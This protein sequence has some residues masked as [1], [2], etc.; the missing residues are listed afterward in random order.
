M[1]Y[2]YFVSFAIVGCGNVHM[3]DF[4]NAPAA[5]NAARLVYAVLQSVY[6]PERDTL[7]TFHDIRNPSCPR[8]QCEP[9]NRTFAVAIRKVPR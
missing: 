6:E 3:E 9:G 7:P 8:I 1:K 4:G 5:M 2:R